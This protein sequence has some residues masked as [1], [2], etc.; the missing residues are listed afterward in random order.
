MGKAL[1]EFLFLEYLFAGCGV[2][3]G[4]V[5]ADDGR[6]DMSERVSEEVDTEDGQGFS[7]RVL[8]FADDIVFVGVL[9]AEVAPESH[10]IAGH[11]GL[12]EFEDDEFL[13]SVGIFDARTEVHPEHSECLTD[14]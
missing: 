5:D 6:L 1:Y 14:G 8:A 4:T 2:G 11:F 12:L 7:V 9:L 3:V 13:A 10:D